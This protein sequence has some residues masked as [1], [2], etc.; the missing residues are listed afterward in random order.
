MNDIVRIEFVEGE[1]VV[2]H[3]QLAEGLEIKAK[4][5]REL[6]QKHH[7]DFEQFGQL[8]FQ[9]ETVKNT[10]GA[11]N[12]KKIYYLN[13]Q[14]ATLALTYFRNSD[15]VRAFKVALVK[16]FFKMRSQLQGTQNH[17]LDRAFDAIARSQEQMAQGFEVM[18]QSVK[19]LA[20]GQREIVELVKQLQSNT[21]VRL[22]KSKGISDAQKE[23][24][25]CVNP[26][27]HDNPE[28][29]EMFTMNIASILKGYPAG[30]SQGVLLS[31]SDYPES[32]RTRRWLQDGIGA[33]WN[34]Q[35]KPGRGYLYFL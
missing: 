3:E 21:P 25:V 29:R 27:F 30:L 6:L 9:T 26:E 15:T 13:E 34:M 11:V 8:P 16:S 14:Q 33:F 2:S 23:R 19:T 5:V 20:D 28:E 22:E 31:K 10:V 4:N 32:T 35:I 12:N 18:A 7:E 1:A 24:L 17:T